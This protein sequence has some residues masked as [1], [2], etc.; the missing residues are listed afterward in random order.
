[1]RVARAAGGGGGGLDLGWPAF[2]VPVLIILGIGTLATWIP[3]RRV[4]KIDPAALLRTT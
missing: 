1:M 2:T 4:M 3:S